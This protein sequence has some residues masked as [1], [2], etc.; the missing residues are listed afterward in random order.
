MPHGIYW[1]IGIKSG[2]LLYSVS[3]RLT[4]GKT[5]VHGG[6][7]RRCRCNL[8]TSNPTLGKTVI[9]GSVVRSMWMIGALST[10]FVRNVTPYEFDNCVY[11]TASGCKESKKCCHVEMPEHPHQRQRTECGFLLL[12]KQHTKKGYRL[13]PHKVHPY[14]PLKRSITKLMNK[15]QFIS[16]CQKWEEINSITFF[17]WHNIIIMMA[18][19]GR[20]LRIF[21]LTQTHIYSH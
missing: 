16:Q 6:R 21:W 13:V 12:K 10:L 7:A 17:L 2:H 19:Y 15:R 20:R 9:D 3:F 14:R 1:P 4:E 8:F 5:E 11:T 18:M